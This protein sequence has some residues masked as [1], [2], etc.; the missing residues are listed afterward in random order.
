VTTPFGP[1]TLTGKLAQG[2][3]GVLYR[4]RDPAGR[5]VAI[6]VLR[7][8]GRISEV[9]ARRFQ[10]EAE[11]L[12]KLNHP[13]VVR[14][15]TVGTHDGKPYIVMDLVEG[16]SLQERLE[17]AGPLGA[18]EAAGIVRTLAEALEHAHGKGVLHRDVKPDNVLLDK[19]EP[20]LTDFGLARD[21][22]SASRLTQTGA[23]MGTPGFC[24]IE[25]ALGQVDAV[26]PASDVF[27]LGATLY[28]LLTGVPPFEAQS[29][30]E[31]V[32]AMHAAPASPSR[33]RPEVESGLSAVCLQC[34]RPEP[35]DR[36]PTAQAL[37]DDL[38]RFLG[39]RPVS[40]S[41]PSLARQVRRWAVRYALALW[42]GAAGVIAVF[43]MVAVAFFAVPEPVAPAELKASRRRVSA[44]ADAA[45]ALARSHLRARRFAEGFAALADVPA[46]PAEL[47]WE[48]GRRL[49]ERGLV[50]DD[51]TEASRCL[52]LELA[53]RAF[54]RL[55]SSLHPVRVELAR[56]AIV[57][58][59]ESRAAAFS[60][61]SVE[62]IRTL[63]VRV[64]VA[65]YLLPEG[66]ELNYA[67]VRGVLDACTSVA[68]LKV[69]KERSLQ[70]CADLAR[71]VAGLT[72]NN[73]ETHAKAVVLSLNSMDVEVKATLVPVARRLAQ[74]DD[75]SSRLGAAAS[76]LMSV[77]EAGD[78]AAEQEGLALAQRVLAQ[79][80]TG[81]DRALLLDE[82]ARTFMRN[83]RFDEALAD[84]EAAVGADS[85]DRFRRVRLGRLLAK[86]GQREKAREVLWLI[87][88]RGTPDRD[89][90]YR[91]ATNE[92]W[93]LGG[94][95][96]PRQLRKATEAVLAER[97]PPEHL[98]W[99]LRAAILAL[100]TDNRRASLQWLRSLKSLAKT[101][102][103][104]DAARV[105]R[106]TRRAREAGKEALPELEALLAEHEG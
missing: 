69:D 10:R 75:D 55:P 71:A 28:A 41:S 23:F 74:L 46:P 66:S 58:S 13:N 91:H 49:V 38:E 67:D 70:N 82:R 88:E 93:R 68:Q 22:E 42:L 59:E 92:L 48:L 31:V 17:R 53:V 76:L 102:E 56:R 36:Y 25:Q 105:Q 33:L 30:L 104:W 1:Y 50:E 60:V 106:L 51:L 26:G 2:G 44:S 32:A 20:R 72:P 35:Q 54:G 12:A 39:D 4:A 47:V 83:K 29:L 7:S 18:R 94:R 65:A 19:G 45:I 8:E 81:V 85:V 62:T 64:R 63:Q 100:E 14:V 77:G 89:N 52:G 34:L 103:G 11:A 78:A 98:K 43:L 87:V 21:L 16:E 61:P 97:Q 96:R 86:Q 5:D 99:Q 6:K 84:I 37:A 95:A 15:H 24:S 9:Q 90:T 57:F 73:A 79:T 80:M 40:A 27:G 3:M 101:E